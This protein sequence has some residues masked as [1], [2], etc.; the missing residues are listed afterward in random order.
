[1]L[2]LPPAMKL[3]QGYI[4]TGVYDSVHR[5]DLPQCVL[6]YHPPEAGTPS[7]CRAC[8]EIRLLECNLILNGVPLSI[9]LIQLYFFQC[10]IFAYMKGMGITAFKSNDHRKCHHHYHW[11]QYNHHRLK[12][13][14]HVISGTAI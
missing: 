2:S 1:M 5:G 9:I 4:F 8:W 12:F 10:P 11:L 6:G 3:G 7:Q 14:L 13:C